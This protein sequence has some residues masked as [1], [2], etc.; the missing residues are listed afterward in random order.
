MIIPKLI[1][2]ECVYQSSSS[3]VVFSFSSVRSEKLT[4][5]YSHGFLF[6]ST[7]HQVRQESISD[8][9]PSV[10]FRK[11]LADQAWDS[12]STVSRFRYGRPYPSPKPYLPANQ[13]IEALIEGSEMSLLRR[14]NANHHPRYHMQPR[15]LGSAWP[16][17]SDTTM[18]N[19]IQQS[20][21]RAYA[22]RPS[23]LE[24]FMGDPEERGGTVIVHYIKKDQ[25]FTE[26][27]LALLGP[28]S[29][30]RPKEKVNS[31]N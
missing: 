8:T 22:S 30:A 24:R 23:R 17:H 29:E 5:R 10:S 15:P 16:N 14:A 19:V 13:E 11:R 7:V 18:E 1:P 21:D 6:P 25:W 12:Y 9:H 4:V 3:Q 28:G 31:D 27:W 26:T 20:F 2:C